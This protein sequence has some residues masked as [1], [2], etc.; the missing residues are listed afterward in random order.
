MITSKSKKAEILTA[1]FELLDEL[2]DLKKVDSTSLL[3]PRQY[4]QDFQNRMKIHRYE[5]SELLN[6]IK[7]VSNFVRKNTEQ[8]S[9][10]SFIK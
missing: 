4:Q 10:P 5:I 7:I 1:Y 9:L 8:V 3:S 2:N 6:H